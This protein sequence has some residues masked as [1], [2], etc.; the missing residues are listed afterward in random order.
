MVN[1]DA[2]ALQRSDL[3]RFL[4]ADIGEEA[5]G[6]P[7]SVLSGLARQGL[8]PWQEAGRLAK[9]PQSAAIDGLARMIAASLPTLPDATG[10]AARLVALLPARGGGAAL[11]A[12]AQPMAPASLLARARSVV[13]G[14]SAPGMTQSLKRVIIGLAVAIVL[15]S[16]LAWN[17]AG[18]HG[19]AG[20]EVNTRL[21]PTVQQPS[22]TR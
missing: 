16:G 14:R 12:R 19:S 5:N 17:L 15:L 11:A 6:M 9:L 22:K 4:F 13:T 1:T 18:S 7:L 8:D 21:P 2:Y 3:N 20:D 10:S